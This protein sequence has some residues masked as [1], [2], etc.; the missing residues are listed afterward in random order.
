MVKAIKER[1][2]GIE[3][4]PLVEVAFGNHYVHSM[5]SWSLFLALSGFKTFND[6]EL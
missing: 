2:I 3:V 6:F 4:A 1:I 5:T